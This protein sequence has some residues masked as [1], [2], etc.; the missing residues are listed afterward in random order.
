MD[1]LEP[2]LKVDVPFLT[3]LLLQKVQPVDSVG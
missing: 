2:S 3:Y 1:L